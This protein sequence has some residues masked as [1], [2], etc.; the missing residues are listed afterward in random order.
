MTKPRRV[1][2]RIEITPHARDGLGDH[3]DQTGMTQVATAS[4]LVEWFCRQDDVIQA[5][6]LGL[7]PED[8]SANL[9]SMILKSI[10]GK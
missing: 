3:C 2:M 1:I 5:G 6:V 10:A 4:R 8:L 9:P 7:F